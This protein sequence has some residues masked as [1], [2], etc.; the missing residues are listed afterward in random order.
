MEESPNYF[1]NDTKIEA[2]VAPIMMV[3]ATSSIKVVWW[4]K[5]IEM[6][7]KKVEGSNKRFLMICP[8]V[9][10]SSGSW[11]GM[12][13]GMCGGTVRKAPFCTDSIRSSMYVV[14]FSATKHVCATSR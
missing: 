14:S 12:L 10:L 3:I 11:W 8:L 4:I 6:G 5:R 13:V 7:L 9:S 2:E 1:V